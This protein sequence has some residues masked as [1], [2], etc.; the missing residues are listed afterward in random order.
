MKRGWLMQSIFFFFFS[1]RIIPMGL[2][3]QYYFFSVWMTRHQRKWPAAYRVVVAFVCVCM[4]MCASKSI[5]ESSLQWYLWRTQRKKKERKKKWWMDGECCAFIYSIQSTLIRSRNDQQRYLASRPFFTLIHI[6]TSLVHIQIYRDC[7]KHSRLQE[8]IGD[9]WEL[10]P[11]W[12]L[13]S[14]MVCLVQGRVGKVKPWVELVA[15]EKN[16]WVV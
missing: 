4:C 5:E 15:E 2:A 6:H 7:K 12:R 11:W 10:E 16:E 8:T 9:V 14:V 1:V 13:Y 3:Y